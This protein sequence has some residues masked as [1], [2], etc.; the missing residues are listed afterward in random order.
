[1]TAGVNRGELSSAISFYYDSPW[2]SAGDQ[3]LPTIGSTE[4]SLPVQKLWVLMNWTTSDNFASAIET[5]V[6]AQP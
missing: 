6:S 5:Q 2:T 1:M 3:S 4:R